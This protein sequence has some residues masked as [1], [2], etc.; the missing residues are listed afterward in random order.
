MTPALLPSR[1]RQTGTHRH[2]KIGGSSGRSRAPQVRGL[3][4]AAA[5]CDLPREAY[6]NARRRGG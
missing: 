2:A 5:I 3:E 4:R 6:N 1:D